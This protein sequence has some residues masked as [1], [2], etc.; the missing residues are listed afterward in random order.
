[1]MLFI[2]LN[3]SIALIGPREITTGPQ[4]TASVFIFDTWFPLWRNPAVIPIL[5]V[6]GGLLAWKAAPFIIKIKNSPRGHLSRYRF[7]VWSIVLLLA[8]SV[9][10]FVFEILGHGQTFAMI[11][12]MIT[13]TA[14]MLII[15]FV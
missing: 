6:I 4:S 14:T 7:L 5:G 8:T 11:G 1:M 3:Y 9:I 10:T 12:L 13:F 2:F 15:N